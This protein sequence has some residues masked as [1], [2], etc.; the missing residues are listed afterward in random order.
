MSAISIAGLE[1]FQSRLCG[2]NACPWE[3]GRAR[4]GAV[5]GGDRKGLM[6]NKKGQILARRFR[7]DSL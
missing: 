6:G 2:M 1:V 7:D 3:P 4:E 5:K